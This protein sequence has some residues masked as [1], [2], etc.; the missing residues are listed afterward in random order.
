MSFL[1]KFGEV[2]TLDIYTL[3]KIMVGGCINFSDKKIF[4]EEAKTISMWR[5]Y[6]TIRWNNGPGK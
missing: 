4:K 3:R 2:S 1:G 6:E 5:G